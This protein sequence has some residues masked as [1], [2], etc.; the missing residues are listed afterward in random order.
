VQLSSY[1]GNDG[2]K[3]S[4]VLTGGIADFGHATRIDSNGAGKDYNQL[5]LVLD[6]GSFRLNISTIEG[7]LVQEFNKFPSNRTTCSGVV[8][9]TGSSPIVAGTG[10]GAYKGISGN[11]TM[12][13]TVNEVDSWPHC[14]SLL[15]ETIYT[16]GSGTISHI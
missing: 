2:P 3:A 10:T 7:T 14:T 9:A 4:L 11:F 6:R 8:V 15:A 1:S 16:S 13:I 5:I 12:T